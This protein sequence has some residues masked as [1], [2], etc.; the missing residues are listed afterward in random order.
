MDVFL[1]K[2]HVESNPNPFDDRYATTEGEGVDNKSG[3]HLIECKNLAPSTMFSKPSTARQ[4]IDYFQ[5]AD[6]EHKMVWVCVI[7]LLTCLTRP[8]LELLRKFNVIIVE[9]GFQVSKTNFGK[10][11]YRLFRSRLYYLLKPSKSKPL[12]YRYSSTYATGNTTTDTNTLRNTDNFIEQTVEHVRIC[13][14]IGLKVI[15]T[16]LL[17]FLGNG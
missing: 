13:E 5:R 10:A 7:S 8:A 15:K 4:L 11:I 2:L 17:P 1:N 6:P 12:L 3:E 9:I 16:G 14:K